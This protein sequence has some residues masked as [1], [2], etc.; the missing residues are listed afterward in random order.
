MLAY[1]SMAPTVSNRS[2]DNFHNRCVFLTRFV[3]VWALKIE[4][5]GSMVNYMAA[6]RL[7][8]APGLDDSFHGPAQTEAPAN[9]FM[10]PFMAL[11]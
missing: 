10:I 2:L 3:T 8:R 1:S 6:E 7:T 4:H 9:S 11:N 5:P